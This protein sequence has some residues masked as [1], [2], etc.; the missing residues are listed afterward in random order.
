MGLEVNK[1]MRKNY[2]AWDLGCQSV[3]GIVSSASLKFPIHFAKFQALP[4]PF[5]H[6]ITLYI[7]GFL[8]M[9]MRSEHIEFFLLLV[10]N[11]VVIHTI[12]GI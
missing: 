12:I 4:N 8:G 10:L 7:Y 11:M 1:R 9:V 5:D 6:Y 2:I 3:K